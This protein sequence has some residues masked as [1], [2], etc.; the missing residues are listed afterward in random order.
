MFTR[1]LSAGSGATAFSKTFGASTYDDAR[2]IATI[3]GSEIYLTGAM[4]GPL[5]PLYQGSEQGG[6]IRE[7]NSGGTPVWT[8]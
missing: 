7:Q 5:A 6:C 3:G 1:K 2:G 8:R 4:K